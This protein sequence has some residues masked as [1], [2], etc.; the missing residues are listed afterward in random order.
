[1]SIF[2]WMIMNLYIYIYIYIYIYNTYINYYM[3]LLKR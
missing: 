2:I 3:N 1:M